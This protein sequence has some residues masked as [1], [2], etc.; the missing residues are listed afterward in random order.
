MAEELVAHLNMHRRWCASDDFLGVKTISVVAC[1][2]HGDVVA[3][4][5]RLR[6][7]IG[8]SGSSQ[9]RDIDV[10]STPKTFGKGANRW[11]ELEDVEGSRTLRGMTS[12][13]SSMILSGLGV[14]LFFA[15]AD[16]D[17][18]GKQDVDSGDALEDFPPK[19]P[20]PK[21]APR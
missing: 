20:T 2:R 1:E 4:K 21:T 6:S 5:A 17:S 11:W 14:L 3:L 10:K 15:A 9:T 18:G 19:S 7:S 8:C 16:A 12:G 13:P